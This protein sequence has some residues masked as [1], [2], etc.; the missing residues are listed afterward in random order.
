[1]RTEG[2]ALSVRLDDVEVKPESMTMQANSLFGWTYQKLRQ[3]MPPKPVQRSKAHKQAQIA[4]AQ[5]WS[6]THDRKTFGDR[7][8]EIAVTG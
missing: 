2:E 6:S 7:S 8:H 5:W 4:K 1:M 3:S